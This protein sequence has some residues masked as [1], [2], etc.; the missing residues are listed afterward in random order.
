MDV[1]MN[2]TTAIARSASDEVGLAVL[3]RAM[4]VEA[5]NMAALVNAI[6]QPATPANL[7]PHLGQHINVLA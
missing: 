7:P 5:Q 3:K 1:S 2:T 4:D 6:P